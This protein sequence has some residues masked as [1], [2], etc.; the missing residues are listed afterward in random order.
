[1]F[2]YCSSKKH[3]METQNSTVGKLSNQCCITSRFSYDIF[4][5]DVVRARQSTS[6][7]F[8][9]AT[10]AVMFSDSFSSTSFK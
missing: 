4:D 6:F 5:Y 1:V 2:R 8:L 9:R 7:F 3:I 10:S